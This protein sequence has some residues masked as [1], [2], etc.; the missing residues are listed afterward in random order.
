MVCLSMWLCDKLVTCPGCRPAFAQRNLGL[1][2]TTLSA[3]AVV[4]ENGLINVL[5]CLSYLL[6]ILPSLASISTILKLTR[7]RLSQRA[8]ATPG[9]GVCH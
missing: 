8:E 4:T 1:D 5:R 6:R 3:A 7:H 2:L 9:S